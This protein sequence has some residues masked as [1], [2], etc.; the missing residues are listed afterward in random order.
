MKRRE[1]FT[2]LCC[3]AVAWPVLAPAADP[4]IQRTDA[5]AANVPHIETVRVKPLELAATSYRFRLGD[6]NVRPPAVMV[7]EVRRKILGLTP[8][9]A[10]GGAETGDIEGGY[11]ANFVVSSLP[12]STRKASTIPV[13]D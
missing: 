4:P 12:L 6:G 5:A 3:A 9:Q 2:L 11:S 7:T 13:G 10:S 1:F 8:D